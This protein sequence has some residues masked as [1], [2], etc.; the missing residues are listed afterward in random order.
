M[1]PLLATLLVFAQRAV[2]VLPGPDVLR[3]NPT[4]A[5]SDL[6]I[7]DPLSDVQFIRRT[8]K[9]RNETAE[10]VL[11][12]AP[13]LGCACTNARI[14]GKLINGYRLAT[15]AEAGVTIDLDFTRIKVGQPHELLEMPNLDPREVEV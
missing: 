14:D 3:T 15:G 9:I 5:R 2:I 7:I 13:Q 1:I 6:G 10:D 8:F 4:W 12:S 11:L